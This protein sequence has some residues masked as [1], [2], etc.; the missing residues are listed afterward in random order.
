MRGGCLRRPIVTG[1]AVVALA[2][3]L[4]ACGGGG[5]ETTTPVSDK[6]ADSEILNDILSRQ[7]GAV[8]AYDHS[9]SHLGGRNLAL[10]RIFRAQEQEHIDSIVKALRGLGGKAE[11]GTEEIPADKLKT[12]LD[13]L[14]LL[15]E[16]ESATI[17]AELS[18]ISKLTAPWPRSLLA[19]IAADQAQ[20]LTLLRGRMGARP[21]DT[22]PGAFENGTATA[23]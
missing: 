15:Y 8:A 12:E 10:A 23:P 20:H 1:L 19:S 14:R 17:D 7:T 3:G 5:G 4:T 16:V 22:V 21:I 18:A 6:Q 2:A 13:Y 11:T 9:L